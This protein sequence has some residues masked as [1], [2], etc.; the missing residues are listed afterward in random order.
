[1]AQEISSPVT[2]PLRSHEGGSPTLVAPAL[3]GP[4]RQNLCPSG[5]SPNSPIRISPA[6]A[7][8]GDGDLG[9][10]GHPSFPTM[11][12]ACSTVSIW[13]PSP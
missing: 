7:G 1:M 12:G 2:G 9:F 6:A 13:S 10:P 8:P 4:E 3:L 5:L 11:P